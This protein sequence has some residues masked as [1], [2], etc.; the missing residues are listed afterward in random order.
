MH[1]LVNVLEAYYPVVATKL[2][3]WVTVPKYVFIFVYLLILPI[4]QILDPGLIRYSFDLFRKT[5]LR[6]GCKCPHCTSRPTFSPCMA[7]QMTSGLRCLWPLAPP[8]AS[9]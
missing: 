9:S 1:D 3:I 2:W 6:E 8:L 7:L 5:H 4:N